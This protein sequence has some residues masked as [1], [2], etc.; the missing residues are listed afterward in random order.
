MA[1]L[2]HATDTETNMTGTFTLQKRT[3]T[4]LT[5]ETDQKYI[6]K[7]IVLTLEAKPATPTYTG[8]AINGSASATYS[9]ATTSNTNTS[10]VSVQ[11]KA[12]ANR[13]NVTYSAAVNGWVNANN[14][15][16]AFSGTTSAT[17]LTPETK[18]IT[19]VN[20]GTSKNFDITV[21]NG[22]DTVTFNFAVDGNGNVL[23][24]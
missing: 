20:I 2:D 12:S 23:V 11:A 6:P 19:G 3:G 9:N 7:D 8:G 1:T 18:Y 24:T 14:G 5:L 17:T 4:I 13:A 15:A 16:T 21:P 10:G 22:E